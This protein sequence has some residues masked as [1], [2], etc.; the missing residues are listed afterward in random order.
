M[1]ALLIEVTG[2][3]HRRYLQ[4]RLVILSFS[5]CKGLIVISIYKGCCPNLA[6]HLSKSPSPL[7]LRPNHSHDSTARRQTRHAR[8]ILVPTHIHFILSDNQAIE[9]F[10]HWPF[11]PTFYTHL[12]L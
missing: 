7:H 11:V 3:V 5:M 8:W 1:K 2:T 12:F 6:R 10:V 4:S 9:V